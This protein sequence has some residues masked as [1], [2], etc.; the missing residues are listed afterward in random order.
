MDVADVHSMSVRYSDCEMPLVGQFSQRCGDA[1]LHGLSSGH[2]L[3][4]GC[5]MG[6]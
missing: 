5:D 4:G 1:C 3:G 2:V 6:H